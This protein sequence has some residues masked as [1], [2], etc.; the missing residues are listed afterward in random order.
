MIYTQNFMKIGADDQTILR[1][2]LRN[3]KG[4]NVG[5]TDERDL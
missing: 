1:G 2:C 4:C 5:V 3:L